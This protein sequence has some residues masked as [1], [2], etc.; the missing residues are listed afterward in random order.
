MVV[1][2]RSPLGK[3]V[4]LGRGVSEFVS[5]SPYNLSNPAAYA[6][7]LTSG[8]DLGSALPLQ[9]GMMSIC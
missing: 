8:L 4:V 7:M 5:S 2:S 3:K 1:E 9:Q 6:C